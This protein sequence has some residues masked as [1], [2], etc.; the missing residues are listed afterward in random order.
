MIYIN[1]AFKRANPKETYIL[2]DFD[3]TLTTHDSTISWG[4]IEESPL[5]HPRLREETLELYKHYRE[6][7]IDPKICSQAKFVHMENWVKQAV[8][9]YGKYV[10]S[11]EIIIKTLKH[12]NRISLRKNSKH[13]LE[14]MQQLEIPVI[15]TSAG[16]GTVIDDFLQ[17]EG[18]MYENITILSNFLTFENGIVNGI[19]PPIIHSLNKDD[20]DYSNLISGRNTGI[21]FGDQ[22]EDIKTAQGREVTK[23]G[24]CDTDTFSLN[25]YNSTFDITLTGESDLDN[26][27]KV[28]IKGYKKTRN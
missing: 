3:R 13:F 9:V 11:E 23:V 19:K 20:I 22:I 24:F 21:L 17:T 26:V 5:V 2:M 8:A 10:L 25:D 4:V 12:Y 1:K 18:C 28:L 14:R 6:I 16:A 15:I 7:E 27:A